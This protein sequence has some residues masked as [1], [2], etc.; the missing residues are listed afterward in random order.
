M[1]APT[2]VSQCPLRQPSE[3]RL[4]GMAGRQEQVAPVAG[5]VS[6]HGLDGRSL[7]RRCFRTPNVQV[8][9]ALIPVESRSSR[10]N[11]PPVGWVFQPDR[12]AFATM[13]ESEKSNLR[14]PF[15]WN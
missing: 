2:D 9:V 11:I 10:Y 13:L 15:P 12:V 3:P 7:R 8:H 14:R 1:Q 6:Q 4:N 5:R